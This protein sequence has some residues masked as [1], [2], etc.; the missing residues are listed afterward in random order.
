MENHE[1]LH[2]QDTIHIRGRLF[3]GTNMCCII[4]CSEETSSRKISCLAGV[5]E[6]N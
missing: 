6:L 1:E 5:Y 3:G 4:G 2:N